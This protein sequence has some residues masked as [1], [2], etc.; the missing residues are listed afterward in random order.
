MAK[1]KAYD[2]KCD[3][4]GFE[5]EM[6]TLYQSRDVLWSCPIDRCDGEMR[7]ILSATPGFVIG[8]ADGKDNR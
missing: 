5:K 3:E 7:R 8:R 1:L 2:Y 4:C 6:Y